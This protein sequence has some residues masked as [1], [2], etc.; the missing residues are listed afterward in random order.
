MNKLNENLSEI[1][2][3]EQINQVQDI[4]VD[5]EVLVSD[6]DVVDVVDEDVS[7]AR[8]NIKNLLKK[9]NQAMDQ[10][11]IV[12]KETQSPRAFEVVATL[13]KNMSELNKDLIDLQKKK[14]D[15]S[16]KEYKQQNINVD[17][18]VVFTGSTTE[19]IKLIKQAKED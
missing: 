2:D 7:F 15:L 9:G 14:R 12:A 13:M 16:P 4:Q 8:G 6:I 19:L 5:S 1:L 18:A 17:K 3:I 10:L 11:L